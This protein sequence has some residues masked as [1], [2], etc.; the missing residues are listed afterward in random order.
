MEI[1][2]VADTWFCGDTCHQ[3]KNMPFSNTNSSS[4]FCNPTDMKH[5][6]NISSEWL[7][8]LLIVS[9]EC[10]IYVCQCAILYKAC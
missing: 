8:N 3:V 2:M 5:S 6:P 10:I 7:E 4:T 1:G 9:Y